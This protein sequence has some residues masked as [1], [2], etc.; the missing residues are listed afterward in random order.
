M[1]AN[2]GQNFGPPPKN[3]ATS[4]L[5]QHGLA[6]NT[7][8]EFLGKSTSEGEVVKGS[9]DSVKLDFGLYSTALPEA[10]RKQWPYDFGLVYSVSLSREGLQTVMQVRNE[11]KEAF[12]FQILLHTYLRIDVSNQCHISLVMINLTHGARTSPPPKSPVSPPPRTLT[13]FSTQS[14]SNR[15]RP[16]S[17]SP[18]RSIAYT[19]TS[20]SPPPPSSLQVSHASML[21]ATT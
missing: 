8:W 21:C 5:P 20:S 19:T 11:G 1:L 7:R 10:L 9:D 13:R 14:S 4:A 18:A 12:D 3:H 16:K 2:H 17:Q 15:A 6:R